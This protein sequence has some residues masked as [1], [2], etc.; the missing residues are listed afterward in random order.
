MITILEDNEKL[1]SHVY[2]PQTFEY[3]L[4][5]P[6]SVINQPLTSLPPPMARDPDS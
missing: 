5:T 3:P 1:Q 2:L 4:P 6:T